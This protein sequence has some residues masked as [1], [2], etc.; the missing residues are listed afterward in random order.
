[1]GTHVRLLLRSL[2]A[3]GGPWRG[4]SPPTGPAFCFFW[5]LVLDICTGMFWLLSG[6]F[7]YLY[8]HVLGTFGLFWASVLV[9]FGYFWVVVGTFGLCCIVLGIKWHVLGTFGLFWVSVLACFGLFWVVLGICTGM[10]CIVLGTFGLFWV[11]LG[12][13][14]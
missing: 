1:M 12:C 3:P 7:G 13:L 2:E 14:W 5:V 6:C 10:F 9:C 4:A 11:L 8:W